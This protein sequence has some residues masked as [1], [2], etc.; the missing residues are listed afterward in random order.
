MGRFD[1]DVQKEA[2]VSNE[3]LA[4][5]AR[6]RESENTMDKLQDT[7]GIEG[8]QERAVEHP[9]GQ[10][11]VAVDYENVD[12]LDPQGVDRPKQ[13]ESP[14]VIFVPKKDFEA[15]VNQTPYNFVKDVPVK[16]T[17]DVAN[18]LQEDSDRGYVRD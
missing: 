8:T 2:N 18:M 15:R 13:V 6:Q 4:D 14:T 5:T 1:K 3:E 9:T 12:L 7:E 16:V 17:R 11:S 10:Q